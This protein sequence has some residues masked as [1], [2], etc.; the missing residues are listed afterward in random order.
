M[1][2]ESL[3]RKNSDI[4]SKKPDLVRSNQPTREDTGNVLSPK[5][6]GLLLRGDDSAPDT[7]SMIIRVAVLTCI[8]LRSEQLAGFESLVKLSRVKS[9]DLQALCCNPSA[10]S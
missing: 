2:K 4:D 3:T 10:K 1:K 6:V 7:W 9:G 5:D 8:S